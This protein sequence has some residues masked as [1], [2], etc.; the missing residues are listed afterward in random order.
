MWSK[1]RVKLIEML[2]LCLKDKVDFQMTAYRFGYRSLDKGHQLPTIA[3]I[4]NGEVV[5]RTYKYVDNPIEQIDENQFDTDHLFN[6]IRKYIDQKHELTRYI[7]DKYMRLLT[8][9]DK[10]N[11]KRTITSLVNDYYKC[12]NEQLKKIYEIRF[13]AENI[14]Y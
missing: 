3:I 13:D 4:Y 6:S 2:P 8:L 10:R 11:G 9:L 5:L 7:D 14:N 1:I 12:E